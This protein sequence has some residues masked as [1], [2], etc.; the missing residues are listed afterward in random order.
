VD[1]EPLP[2]DVREILDRYVDNVDALDALIFLF[3]NPSRWWALQ[4]ISGAVDISTDAARRALG[5]LKSRG[6]VTDAAGALYRFAQAGPLSHSAYATLSR[7]CGT[8]RVA[9]VD[10]LARRALGRIRVLADAF[11]KGRTS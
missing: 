9:V 8:E 3:G 4:E 5:G 2:A 1:E 10:Y 11:T 6:L 7:A